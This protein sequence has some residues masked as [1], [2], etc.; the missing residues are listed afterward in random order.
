MIALAVL[1][2]LPVLVVRE[3]EEAPV[4]LILVVLVVM[5]L[6]L[7]VIGHSHSQVPLAAL[8][9][10]H[11]SLDVSRSWGWLL[12]HCQN[13]GHVVGERWAQTRVVAGQLGLVVLVLEQVLTAVN[14]WEKGE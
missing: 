10:N 2:W 8:D 14:V 11:D 7:L 13:E 3:R 4:L 1:V 12:A 6:L 5:V 9:Q